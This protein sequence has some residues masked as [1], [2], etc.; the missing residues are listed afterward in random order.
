M[1]LNVI[2]RDE[3]IKEIINALEI[4]KHNIP[5][6]SIIYSGVNR[7][8]IVAL[9]KQVY[10]IAQKLNIFCKYIRINR[11]DDFI[12]IVEDIEAEFLNA[13]LKKGN[14]VCIDRGYRKSLTQIFITVGKIAYEIKSL[15]PPSKNGH[16]KASKNEMNRSISLIY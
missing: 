12:S 7:V 14:E 9:M 10:A 1:C 2:S 15:R 11:K 4:L 13:T 5:T 3:N 16:K 8:Q 6:Q